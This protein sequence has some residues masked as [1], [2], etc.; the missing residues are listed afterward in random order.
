M[1]KDDPRHMYIVHAATRLAIPYDDSRL[2]G[3]CNLILLEKL[4]EQVGMA[5][6]LFDVYM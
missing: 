2:I 5:L 4:K 1:N 6:V 3:C